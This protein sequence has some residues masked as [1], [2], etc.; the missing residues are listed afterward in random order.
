MPEQAGQKYAFL[1]LA[2]ALG[3][4]SKNK[5]R[6]WRDVLAAMQTGDLIVGRRTPVMGMPKWATPEIVR[7]GFATTAFA[8]G[9]KLQPHEFS[10]A[11]RLSLP[12]T[13]TSRLRCSLN[14]W[15]LSDDGLNILRDQA[16]SGEFAAHTPEETALLVVALLLDSAPDSAEAILNEI[17]PFFDRLR[18]YP[19]PRATTGGE[20]V[21]VR[22]V[23]QIRDQLKNKKPRA[24]IILQHKSLVRWIPLY[25]RLVDLLE[26]REQPQ[27]KVL[28]DAWLRDYEQATCEPMARRWQKSNSPFQRCRR[29]LIQIHGGE[30]ITQNMLV[31]VE[32]IIARRKAKYGETQARTTYRNAQAKQDVTVWHDAVAQIVATRLETLPSD[33]GISDPASFAGPI[34]QAEAIAGAPAGRDL[35]KRFVH[36]I[37]T[38][39]MAP[40]ADLVRSGQIGAPEVL[41]KVLPQVTAAIH[42]DGLPTNAEVEVYR[43]LYTAF[44]QRRSLLLLNLQSQVRIEELPWAAALLKRRAGSR[45][46]QSIAREMLSE[47]VRMSL[48]HFPH[49]IFPNPLV[50]EMSNL[51]KTAKLDIPFTSEIASDIFMGDFSSQFSKAATISLA[52]YSGKLYAR[53]YN[54][55]KPGQPVSLSVLCAKRAGIGRMRNWSVAANGMIIEQQQIVTSHNLAQLFTTLD[56][57]D[58]NH[59]EMVTDC[60]DWICKRQQIPMKDWRAKLQ[61]TKN[62]AF[63]WRQMIAFM[64]ELR[65]CEQQSVF[66]EIKK[67]SAA[68]SKEYQIRFAPALEGLERALSGE[69]LFDTDQVVLGWV[70]GKHPFCP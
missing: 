17:T 2:K 38:A 45:N 16:K 36:T 22:S 48:T 28:A 6:Q 25:D 18:F 20:G 10:L 31:D 35:P 40:V 30:P 32:A 64:S 39:R 4:G 55:P 15:H 58:L 1:N 21:F 65:S 47:L 66:E 3:A 49:V 69:T 54:L 43:S 7:G 59:A 57:S 51:G 63:A 62:T 23:E 42:A 27:W 60:F 11:E 14:N 26:A 53:Y 19:V 33:I 29:A 70:Q 68:Q 52:Y 50:Q 41:A 13:D 67:T 61:M 56:L 24:Q 9:G 37:N 8:A 46:S 5:I 12:T 34:Q 44:S